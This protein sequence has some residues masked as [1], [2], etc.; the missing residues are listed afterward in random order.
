MPGIKT[1]LTDDQGQQYSLVT[2]SRCVEMRSGNTLAD[3]EPVAR[4]VSI[5]H[6]LDAYPYV[7]MLHM[8]EGKNAALI[9]AG[10]EYPSRGEVIVYTTRNDW[11]G[12]PYLHKIRSR[13]YQVTFEDN[14]TD[15][16]YIRLI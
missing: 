9:P 5:E 6:D 14:G 16:I 1:R 10:V 15:S 2:D 4:L 13:E 3:Y 8:A 12:M 11:G 7:M